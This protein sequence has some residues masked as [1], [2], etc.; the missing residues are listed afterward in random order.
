MQK[1]PILILGAGGHAAACIDV[2]E[3]EGKF[4]IQGCLGTEQEKGESI[5]GYPVLGT[6]EDLSILIKRCPYVLIG[7]GQIQTP[8][9][10]RK[11]F[12]KARA[13]GAKFPVICSPSSRVSSHAVLGEGT[14][15]MH[16]ALVQPRAM[17]GQNTIL[18]SHCLVEHDV[19]IA[20]D[21]HISTGAILNGGAHVVRGCFIGSRAVLQE[22][23]V[24]SDD[25][26]I[27]MGEVLRR[28]R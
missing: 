25:T 7:V 23:V 17:V 15:V 8:E 4:E 21:C 19:R 16:G 14:I 9:P 28:P 11:L 1:P 22:G 24:V 10:R 3:A 26:V 2:L 20:E 5:L 18:N 27:P 6:D 12:Q 13:L